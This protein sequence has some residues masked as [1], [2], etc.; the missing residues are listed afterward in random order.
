MFAVLSQPKSTPVLLLDSTF[1]ALS[2]NMIADITL[3]V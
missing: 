3:Q 1:P 2:R